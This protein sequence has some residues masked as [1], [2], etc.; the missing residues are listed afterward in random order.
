M[1][2]LQELL[3]YTQQLLAVE[4]YR[5]YCPNGLQ[6]EGKGEVRCIVSGVTASLALLEA[7]V[8]LKADAVLVHHGYF[9]KSE[10]AAIVGMKQ[11]RIKLLLQHDINL[12]AYHLPLDGH[13]ELG[14]NAQLARVFDAQIDNWFGEQNLVAE[15]RLSQPVTLAELAD[16]LGPALGRAAV[17]LGDPGKKVARIAWCSGGAQGMHYEAALRGVDAYISGEAAEQNAHIAAE[18]GVAFIAAGHHATEKFGVQALGAHL[19]QQ[20]GLA[21]HFVDIANPI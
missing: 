1:V 3:D 17:A 6:V 9:W 12:L 21:H 4:R 18:T 19:A 10:P 20:F 14:N 5:D 7:A 16:R 15:G 11:R 2:K 13:P 8:D